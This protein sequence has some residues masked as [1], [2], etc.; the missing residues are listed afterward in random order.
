MREGRKRKRERKKG[1]LEGR[2][3]RGREE[4]LPWQRGSK[5]QTQPNSLC[6]PIQVPE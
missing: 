5:E 1:E 3:M 2:K 6:A 4:A